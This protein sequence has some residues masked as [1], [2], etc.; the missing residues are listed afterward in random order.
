MP[1]SAA[2]LNE[3]GHQFPRRCVAMPQELAKPGGGNMKFAYATGARPLDGY[4]IKRGIGIGGFGEVYFALSDA[5]KEVA[6]KRIQRNMDV[7]VRGVT[8]CLNLKHPNLVAL[9]DIKYDDD[10]QAWVVMEYV[11]GPSLQDSLDRHP[12]G[13]PLPEV[14][15]WFRGIA[16]GVAYLHDHGIVH[17]DLKPANIFLDDDIVKIGDYGL[18][19]YISCSHRSGQTESV[20][21]FHYMA[22]EIGKGVYGK[23]IDIYALGILLCEMLTGHVPFDGESSQ[24]IMMKHLTADPDLTNVPAAFQ[25]IIQ[26]ALLK[27]PT[28]RVLRVSDM[29]DEVAVA[30]GEPRPRAATAKV[31]PPV[32]AEFATATNMQSA[33]PT[34]PH[35]FES[36]P[37]HSAATQEFVT[38]EL[39]AE[40][41]F[42]S[43]ASQSSDEPIAR[44]VS[45]AW[46]N[47]ANW[48]KQ[49][50]LN[51]SVKAFLILGLICLFAFNSTW[52]VPLGTVL[53]A[54][55]L[56]YYGLRSLVLSID[57]ASTSSVRPPSTS[58]PRHVTTTPTAQAAA[59]KPRHGFRRKHWKTLAR[60]QRQCQSLSERCTDLCGS[61]LVSAVACVV[62]CFTS[63]LLVRG[64]ALE[65]V[66]TW[67][68]YAW[69]TLTSIIGAWLILAIAKFWEVDEGE[70]VRRRFVMLIAGLITGTAAYVTSQFLGVQVTNDILLPTVPAMTISTGFSSIDGTLG[71][72][73]FLLYFGGLFGLLKWWLQ[74]DPL[75]QG[76]VSIWSTLGCV[77]GAWVLHQFCQ[78]PQPW[79]LLLA[80]T[81]SLAVQFAAPWMTIVERTKIRDEA[82]ELL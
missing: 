52:L 81:I 11:N 80:A 56:V 44:V 1:N 18:S 14:L 42:R 64:D 30:C 51:G 3:R 63:L 40:S 39:V 70:A 25:P 38:A 36:R 68:L 53:G 46:H 20:G 55:Y 72:P 27:D 31:P 76:R 58:P 73:A 75:R 5:G 37:M 47:T 9:F 79:G 24:E 43:T 62:I 10:E 8:H 35:G 19:K 57:G 7:E 12:Q 50:D 22:P 74:A 69:F 28:R 34:R 67:S 23:E 49:S 32:R 48:W 65:S 66:F 17:R 6:L 13:M 78:F 4:T 59:R 45:D 2:T 16:A 26:H 60:E 21:T 61:W 77:F 54:F 33:N 41:P 82:Q 71:L 29:L 15:S